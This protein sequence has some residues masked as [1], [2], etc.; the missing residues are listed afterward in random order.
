MVSFARMLLYNHISKSIYLILKMFLCRVKLSEFKKMFLINRSFRNL[1][2]I[3]KEDKK[4]DIRPA[5]KK[6]KKENEFSPETAIDDQQ[7]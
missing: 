4:L 6:Y 2:E 1:L 7:Y 5:E 3:N